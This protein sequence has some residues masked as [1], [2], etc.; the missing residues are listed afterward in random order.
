MSTLSTNQQLP[1]NYR[2]DIQGVDP[3]TGDFCSAIPIA[4]LIGNNGLGPVLDLKFFTTP[5][6]VM[7]ALE[8][9]TLGLVRRDIM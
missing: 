8:T 2:R 6:T 3:M 4:T 5:T 9:G 1:T 7:Q